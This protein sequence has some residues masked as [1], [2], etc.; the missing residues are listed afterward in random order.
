M[1]SMNISVCYIS[2]TSP[3]LL[4]LTVS[5]RKLSNISKLIPRNAWFTSAMPVTW[6]FVKPVSSE[7]SYDIVLLC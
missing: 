4:S 7:G 3:S 1:A 2:T 5:I 6:N